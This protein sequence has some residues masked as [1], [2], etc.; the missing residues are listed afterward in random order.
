MAS[1]FRRLASRPLGT[2]LLGGAAGALGGSTASCG[3]FADR[4]A[5]AAGPKKEPEDPAAAA[6]TERRLYAFG[7]LLGDQLADLKCF[8]PVELDVILGGLRSY[9]LGEPVRKDVDMDF[10]GIKASLMLRDRV[11]LHQEQQGGR[12]VAE[13]KVALAKAA[14]EPGAIRTK[15]GLVIQEV[16]CGVG[17]APKATDTVRVHYEGRLLDGTVFDSSVR[18]GSAAEF[19]L[20]GVIK[21]W[22]EGA[23]DHKTPG[24]LCTPH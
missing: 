21:G 4:A 5:T 17:A 23:T 8:G 6:E 11:K 9:V 7:R 10:Y 2:V 22:T 15:S 24:Q 14:A 16:S 19:P 18:R 13:G 1:I 12:N 20:D 3:W